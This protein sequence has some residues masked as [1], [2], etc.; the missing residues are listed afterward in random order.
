MMYGFSAQHFPADSRLQQ[1]AQQFMDMLGKSE[2]VPK[3]SDES[4]RALLH[5]F[6]ELIR[7]WY[8][9]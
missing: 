7:E 8:N 1:I 3:K 9:R 2:Y 4:P 5:S 6:D